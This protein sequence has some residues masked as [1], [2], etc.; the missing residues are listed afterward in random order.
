MFVYTAMLL[1]AALFVL[2]IACVNVA[3]LQFA[4]ATGR[5][6]EIA[7][8]TAL[9]ARRSRLVRQLVTES[10]A[11]AVAGAAAGLLLAKWGR[12]MLQAHVPA[13]LVRDGPGLAEIGLN[14]HALAF[15]L[16]AALGS[17]ILAGL[18]PAIM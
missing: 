11:L 5:W 14:R 13:E 8:R 2:L 3:N 4:R 9:G 17:G 6:R 16:V 7:V 10:M 15:T 18:L 1:G 12:A